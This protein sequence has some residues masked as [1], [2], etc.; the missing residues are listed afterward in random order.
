MAHQWISGSAINS[1]SLLILPTPLMAS[2]P[3]GL[4]LSFFW[5][6]EVF[7]SYVPSKD[8]Y[9]S[10]QSKLQA[11]WI[12]VGTSIFWFEPHLS[13]Y[14]QL[15]V[16]LDFLSEHSWPSDTCRN[17]THGSA[18]AIPHLIDSESLFL[19]RC[20]NIH[21]CHQCALLGKL[22]ILSFVF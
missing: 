4:L 6:W 11:R 7:W 10:S 13:A 19:S 2:A 8:P 21:A 16:F 3:Y 9:F 18:M 5:F 12:F 15:Y 22:R 14:F 20:V 17:C 1:L